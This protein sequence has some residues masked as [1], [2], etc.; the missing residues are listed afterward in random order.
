MKAMVAVVLHRGDSIGM[1][2]RSVEV[3]HD[4]GL[5][6][7]ITGHIPLGAAALAHAIE[8]LHE[9]TG[10][11]VAD[12]DDFRAGPILSLP[13]D[14]GVTR[15]VHTFAAHTT[16]RRLRLKGQHDAY[17]WVK[18]RHVRGFTQTQMSSAV[19]TALSPVH[20]TEQPVQGT[21]TS[22]KVCEE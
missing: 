10:L 8:E 22:R 18:P 3:G 15:E 2:K 12:I 5:W 11:A 9:E 14:D 1:F 16:T 21:T 4:A 17:R 20:G 19:I 7:C 13:G 6:H